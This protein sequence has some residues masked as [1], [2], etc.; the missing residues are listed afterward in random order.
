MVGHFNMCV[1]TPIQSNPSALGLF[2]LFSC[3]FFC[4]LAFSGLL[5]GV[6]EH[7][8]RL[9]TSSNTVDVQQSRIRYFAYA[10][11]VVFGPADYLVAT[12]APDDETVTRNRPSTEERLLRLSSSS[13]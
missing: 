6:R 12:C 8:D 11:Q 7:R 2:P 13:A 9:C 4:H 5:R 1:D 3:G 10:D